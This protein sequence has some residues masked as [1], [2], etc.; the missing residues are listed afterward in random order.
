MRGLRLQWGSSLVLAFACQLLAPNAAAAIVA[1][2]TAGAGTV[3]SIG[4]GAYSIPLALPAGTNGLTPSISL[5]YRHNHPGGLVGVGWSIGG[6]SAIQRCPLTLAQDGYISINDIRYCLDGNR[7]VRTELFL[8]YNDPAQQYRTEIETFSRIKRFGGPP[9]WIPDYFTVE[10]VDGL[11]RE[12]GAT[13]DSRGGWAWRINKIRDRSNNEIRFTYTVDSNGWRL[14]K[15]AYNGNPSQGVT[16]SHEVLFVYESRPNNE[17][18]VAYV[19]GTQIREIVR[20]DRI[21]VLYNTAVIKR[22][23]LTYE[24][25]LSS[26]GNSRLASVQECGVGGADCFSPTTFAWQNGTAGLGPEYSLPSSSCTFADFNGDGFADCAYIH[27]VSGRLSYRLGLSTGGFGTEVDTGILGVGGFPFDYNGDDRKDLLGKLYTGGGINYVWVVIPGTESGL[28]SLINTGISATWTGDFRG[29]DLNG[30]GLGDIIY[31]WQDNTYGA[32]TL[33]VRTRIATQPGVFGAEQVLYEQGYYYPEWSPGAGFIGEPGKFIDLDADGREDALL[34]E[35]YSMVRLSL[36][37]YTIDSFDSEFATCEL[38]DLNGDGSTDFVYRHYTGQYRVRFGGVGPYPGSLPELILPTP[39]ATNG[40]MSVVDWNGDA[41]DDLA[42]GGS[43]GTLR[44]MVSTGETLLP[45]IDTGIPFATLP[46]PSVDINGDSLEDL[47]TWSTGK[48]RLRIG[49]KPDLLTLV[50]DGY[51]VTT[52]FVYHPITVSGVYIK[53]STAQFPDR[54]V[55]NGTHVVTSLVATDGTGTGST[56]S[57]TFTYEGLRFNNHG[58]GY[59]GFG[60]KVRVDGTL[61]YNQKHE[62]TFKQDFPYI[63]LLSNYVLRQSSGQPIVDES[64]TWSSLSLGFPVRTFPYISASQTKQYEAGGAYNGT[65][66]STV[67]SSVAAIDSTSGLITDQTVTTTEVATGINSS[68]VYTRRLLHQS[69]LNDSTY[70][71]LGR[72]QTTQTTATHTLPDGSSITRTQAATWDAVKCRPTQRRIEPSHAVLQATFDYTYDA[73]GNVTT[74]TVTGTGMSPRT[75]QIG[76]G[77]RGQLPLSITNALGHLSQQQWR[78]DFGLPTSTQD[79]NGLSMSWLFDAFGRP[80]LRTRSDS[81]STSWAWTSCPTCGPLTRMRLLEDEKDSTGVVVV[82]TVF[83]LD[84]F[85]RPYTIQTKNV[86]GQWIAVQSEFDA[87]GRLFKRRMPYWYALGPGGYEFFTF[88]QVNRTTTIGLYSSAGVLQHQAS[89]LSNG[90]SRSITNPLGAS[91]TFVRSAWGDTMRS[92]NAASGSTDFQYNAFGQ[93]TKVTDALGNITSTVTYNLRGM[94]T[95]HTDMDMGVWTFAPNALGEITSQTDAKGQLSTFA[96]D[97]LGRMTA[98]SEGAGA[99]TWTW[100][101]SAAAKN[102]GKLE[103]L[104]GLGYSEIL[105]YDSLGRLSRRSIVADSTYDYDY[106]YNSIGALESVQYPVSTTDYR[107]KLN[108]E[109]IHGQLKRIKDAQV[110]MTVLWEVNNVDASGAAIDVSLGVAIRIVSGFNPTTGLLEYRQAGV[111]GST[112]IQNLAYEWN[113]LGYLTKRADLNQSGTCSGPGYSAKLCES[114]TYDVLGR[115]DMAHRNGALNLDI[116]YD[117]IGNITSKTSPTDPAENVGTYDYMTDQPDCT[118]YAHNQ[119][120]AVRTAG[121]TGY[122]Y[123]ANGNMIKRAGATVSWYSFNLPQ[124]INESGGNHSQFFYG[125]ERNRWKQVASYAGVIEST[126]Y[127]GGLVEKVT[128]GSTITW[129]HYIQAP[130]GTAALYQRRS[131]GAPAEETYYLTQDHLA[132]TDKVVRAVGTSIHVSESFGAFGQRRGSNWT[133]LPEAS[134][135]SAI[136]SATRDG[137]TAHEHLDNLTLIHMNGRVF[138]PRIGQFM[139]SDPL[140]PFILDGQ[141]LNRYS[142]VRGAPLTLT[143]PSGFVQQHPPW[144]DAVTGCPEDRPRSDL[145]PARSGGTTW[146]IERDPCSQIGNAF[147][148]AMLGKAISQVA[149]SPVVNMS[150][151]TR[152]ILD[153]TNPVLASIGSIEVSTSY[154]GS[155]YQYI[156]SDYDAKSRVA[157]FAVWREFKTHYDIIAEHRWNSRYPTPPGISPHNLREEIAKKLVKRFVVAGLVMTGTEFQDVQASVLA[158]TV[159]FRSLRAYRRNPPL[160]HAFKARYGPAAA[161]RW[162]LFDFGGDEIQTVDFL[163]WIRGEETDWF[164]TR[165]SDCVLLGECQ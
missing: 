72:P 6:L 142:Y 103:S 75:T 57:Q 156:G 49:P 76:W 138:E 51:G 80:T 150:A 50:T 164:G 26:A 141:S 71:C 19:F 136:D 13:T 84:Q 120:H 90:L 8:G 135:W 15:I 153:S 69:V 111:S 42:F 148:C 14:Q 106:A 16:A 45:P 127:V 3:T 22:Y 155:D 66:V 129:R 122:C 91:D 158:Y 1:G 82:P 23:E 115:I 154:I 28:G 117:A 27:S 74:Q 109:Y 143:D 54:D 104:S 118:Y 99:S 139:S 89:V 56:S 137:F 121:S 30:D 146:T 151:G 131:G 5:E 10:S 114:F 86:S 59:V 79:P 24:Q 9:N 108:Y 126:I 93:I 81:T 134:E 94:K 152:G 31:T 157:R 147:D 35:V 133:G 96:Y 161:I 101:N 61:G 110:P 165:P 100:G 105:T 62:E 162:D 92:T 2:R 48:Y 144:C 125:P 160:G 39:T 77:P 65:H 87:R 68:A 53:G 98:R 70:W 113:A 40:V 130:T 132:S 60:K 43:S 52:G 95:S 58:R 46:G 18:D 37:G 34:S 11:V 25:Y 55:R 163:I 112:A 47:T 83:D 67:A 20:V 21:D 107:L 119:R 17:V 145:F 88:D 97:P 29:L 12:Y 4:E 33:E 41:K 36:D 116:N 73:F 63:G 128:R 44:I 124:V 85:D 38:F 140:V 7:L 64:R 32:N 123:D 78:Y 159:I 102:I 149:A